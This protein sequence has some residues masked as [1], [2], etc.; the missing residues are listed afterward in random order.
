[1]RVPHSK[2][3]ICLHL[4]FD[5]EYV[6]IDENEICNPLSVLGLSEMYKKNGSPL[7]MGEQLRW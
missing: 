1:M 5:N 4:D 7:S 2:P 3:L 6:E